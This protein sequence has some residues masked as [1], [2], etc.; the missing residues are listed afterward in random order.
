M[1][2]FFIGLTLGFALPVLV[3]WPLER[4]F[5]ARQDQPLWRTGSRLDLLYWLCLP[6]LRGGLMALALVPALALGLNSESWFEQGFGR[7]AQQPGWLQVIEF[8]ILFDVSNYWVHRWFHTDRLWKFHA[9]HHSSRQL[10]W[11]STVRHHPINDV[12][13]RLGQA[14]PAVL[15]G[16]SPQVIAWC[17]PVLTFHSLLIHANVNWSFG[18]LGVVIVSPTFH[19][20]HHTSQ[21]EGRDKNFAELCPILD[22]LFGTYYR[23]IGRQPEQ[24]GIHDRSFPEHFLGQLFYPF[25]IAQERME[26]EP[27]SVSNQPAG[28]AISDRTD[29]ATEPA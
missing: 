26:S 11:L 18:P 12:A 28:Q 21:E 4:L 9:V 27:R 15:L 20:W 19:H 6:A 22:I 1:S 2:L 14:L 13:L 24:F 7:L 10:D 5:P 17:L 25:R 3:L 8:L 23:P 29:S 16:Y